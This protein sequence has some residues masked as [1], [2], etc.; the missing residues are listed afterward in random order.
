MRNI[1][2]PS[3]LGKNFDPRSPLRYRQVRHLIKCGVRCVL[4]A[5]LA[6]ERG[7]TLDDALDDFCR[8]APKGFHGTLY[9]YAA[10]TDDE[11]T[12]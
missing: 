9:H 2:R 11:V 6:V 12:S 1:D 8:F 3:G 4:E 10:L 5:L 7:Q